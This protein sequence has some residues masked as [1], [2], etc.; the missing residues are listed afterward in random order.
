[1]AIAVPLRDR[2]GLQGVRDLLQY[3]RART[4]RGARPQRGK[5]P[6]GPEAG[7]NAKLTP[8]LMALL[9]TACVVPRAGAAPLP[10]AAAAEAEVAR[11]IADL[12]SDDPEA[13]RKASV[14]LL[15]L[16]GEASAAVEAAIKRDNLDPG[17][18]AVLR[19]VAPVVAAR[20]RAEARD[21]REIEHG[22]KACVG[23]YD[24]GGKRNPKWDEDAREGIRQWIHR[25]ATRNRRHPYD[26]AKV[27]EP[28]RRALGAGCDDPFVRY[29][30]ARVEG[31]QHGAD[32][33]AEARKLHAAARDLMESGYPPDRKI[34]AWVKAVTIGG[35]ENPDMIDRCLK[36]LPEALGQKDLP[37]RNAYDLARDLMLAATQLRGREAA[38]N[39][40]YPVYAAGRPDEAYPLLLRGNFYTEFAWEAR[41]GGFA[42]TVTPKGW[43]LF[44]ERLAEAEAA[45]TKAWEIDP[46][47]AEVAVEMLTV[48]LGQGGNPQE[49]DTWFKRA[50]EADPDNYDAHFQKLYYLYP[51]WHGSHEAMLEF[52][53]QCL[54]GENW[55]GG[56]PFI[57]VDAHVQIARETEAKDYF[58]RPEVWG[59]VERV[60]SGY[61]E[62]YPENATA[63]SRF[64]RIACDNERW[65]EALRQFAVLGDKPDENVFGGMP[66]YKYLRG[67]AEKAVKASK[68]KVSPPPPAGP[69]E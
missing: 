65:E 69:P 15:N 31:E 66:L 17:T 29:A 32:T 62:L 35:D 38:F 43:K 7:M 47:V 64:A 46:T 10:A 55:R 19:R 45:L 26:D 5:D 37:P 40:V 50:V 11:L 51:R 34:F 42:N 39:A 57:L 2:H 44:G 41:G 23:A 63:R 68:P 6:T 56:I 14:R 59:D 1:M 30:A 28:L 24:R 52:G 49:H 4:P 53:H 13:R 33:Q 60:Y 8:T 3:Q 18:Q 25:T 9:L 48:K 58:K 20:A 12:G 67:K 54:S 36:L 61:L 21:A 27:L 16:G 22:I